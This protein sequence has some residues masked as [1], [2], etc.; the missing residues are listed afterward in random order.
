MKRELW[1]E[2]NN[3]RTGIFG[4]EDD[5]SGNESDCRAKGPMILN[6]EFMPRIERK[7][8]EMITTK[9]VD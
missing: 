3:W 5:E 7:L 1:K 6:M 8:G 9:L 4:P 2:Q